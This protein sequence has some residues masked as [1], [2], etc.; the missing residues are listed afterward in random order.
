MFLAI[1]KEIYVASA[2]K[3]TKPVASMARLRRA[4]FTI[5]EMMAANGLRHSLKVG[6]C[7]YYR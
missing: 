6:S 5:R 2:V 3:Y 7:D 1:V 4:F